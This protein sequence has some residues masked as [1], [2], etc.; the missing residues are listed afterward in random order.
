VIGKVAAPV[1]RMALDALAG[2]SKPVAGA[3]GRSASGAE[4]K[5]LSRMADDVVDPNWKWTGGKPGEV[6]GRDV[7]N[8]QRE[9]WTGQ[10]WKGTEERKYLEDLKETFA[11]Q[12][13]GHVGRNPRGP[14]SENYAK[15][16]AYVPGEAVN[17]VAIDFG[18]LESAGIPREW[19]GKVLGALY[20]FGRRKGEAPLNLNRVGSEGAPVFR[21]NTRT[22]I[23]KVAEE[24]SQAMARLYVPNSPTTTKLMRDSFLDMLPSW[25]GSL[26]ELANTVRALYA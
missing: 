24:T 21:T 7:T 14:I 25:S 16:K 1:A 20:A 26:D 17:N 13:S 12:L 8:A 15:L 18:K 2:G 9:A 10:G 11:K 4:G 19:T 3:V 22:G 5:A 23:A 6:T